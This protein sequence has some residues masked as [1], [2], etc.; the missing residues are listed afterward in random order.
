MI[1]E[2]CVKCG[3]PVPL[4]GQSSLLRCPWC[5]DFFKP[6]AEWIFLLEEEALAL[7]SALPGSFW[8]KQPRVFR[9]VLFLLVVWATIS[10]LSHNLMG[11]LPCGLLVSIGIVF[12]RRRKS[13]LHQKI[14]MLRKQAFEQEE[15]YQKQ[16][17]IADRKME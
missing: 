15:A 5:K 13:P 14:R 4:Q 10:L 12:I 1:E 7:E 3:K 17:L 16:L 8:V 9:P 2:V 11:L 6:Q